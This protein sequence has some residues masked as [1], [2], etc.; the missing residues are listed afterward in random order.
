MCEQIPPEQHQ[1]MMK[2]HQ[3]KIAA[4]LKSLADPNPAKR[5]K[6]ALDLYQSKYDASDLSRPLSAADWNQIETAARNEKELSPQVRLLEQ[7]ESIHQYLSDQESKRR[8]LTLLKEKA[9]TNTPEVS[10]EASCQLS[11]IQL[12]PLDPKSFSL[13]EKFQAP[14]EEYFYQNAIE[15]H[16]VVDFISMHRDNVQKHRDFFV[17]KLKIL[18]ETEESE[19]H[20]M[21]GLQIASALEFTGA[22]LAPVVLALVNRSSPCVAAQ[23]I[24]V[25]PV[26]VSTPEPYP[27]TQLVALT[28]HTYWRV[29]HEAWWILIRSGKMTTV[30]EVDRARIAKDPI[31]SVREIAKHLK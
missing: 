25:W 16:T 8:L 15:G 31:G 3:E 9:A 4:A 22:P 11:S 5:E 10:A 14:T 28:R 23:A 18:F 12:P 26:L 6:A 1:K 2:A 30:P 17:S 7:M 24:R 21:E 29:R 19:K 13:F 27:L 20:L